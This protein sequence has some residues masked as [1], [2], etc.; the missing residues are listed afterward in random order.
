MSKVQTNIAA[1]NAF[2][3]FMTY[4]FSFNGFNCL[5]T[6]NVP[7][8]SR[9]TPKR[10]TTVLL[11]GEKRATNSADSPN[12]ALIAITIAQLIIVASS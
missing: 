3:Y 8:P 4:L 6:E 12:K 2:R 1:S 9:R 5:E 7:Q 11:R 10:W